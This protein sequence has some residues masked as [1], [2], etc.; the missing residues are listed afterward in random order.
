MSLEKRERSAYNLAAGRKR[1]CTIDLNLAE[2][3]RKRTEPSGGKK[4]DLE[5]VFVPASR[6]QDW[7]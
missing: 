4:N 7:D 6:V 1:G 3:T 5:R 2:S